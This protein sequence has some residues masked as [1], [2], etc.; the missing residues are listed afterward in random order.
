MDNLHKH[1]L[2]R[3]AIE[4]LNIVTR[5]GTI[6]R[7]DNDPI[8][9]FPN[10]FTGLGKLEGTYS[11]L[12]EE[13]AKPY[14][15]TVPRRV[16]IPLMQP[17]KEELCRMEKL[18]VISRVKEPTEWCTA[19]VVVPKSNQKVRI[20]VDLTRLNRNVRRVRHPHPA[21]EQ[22]L[23]QLAGARV[24]ST[25]DANSGF[26]QI[27]LDR[28]SALLTTFITP[29]GRYCFHRLP[30]GITSAPEHFQRRMSEILTN[31]DGVVC[32][33]DDVLVHGQTSEEHDKRLEKVL[34]RLQ[35]AGL[36]LNKQKCHF[37]Q[38]QV[39]FLRQIIDKDG[40]PDK[41]RAIQE[42]H[43]PNNVSDVRRFLGMCNH[44][45][46][47]SPNLAEKT[48]PLRELLNKKNHWVIQTESLQ[49]CLC[50]SVVND[51]G[52]LHGTRLCMR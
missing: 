50:A 5:I 20:C 17:V 35:E 15:L 52:F 40:V 16:A 44:L 43:H 11:I 32:M 18:G 19:M 31:L 46:K 14:A 24:F 34:Q 26:W 42:F 9:R 37:S 49:T 21:V 13:G 7:S 1:L 2:G 4:A 33:M 10:L 27:P 12:L 48:K 51:T 6:E 39:K 30:F 23:A 3:P 41:V 25:L 29:F 38:T 28:E 36:T 47:F 22:S 45:S 8:E